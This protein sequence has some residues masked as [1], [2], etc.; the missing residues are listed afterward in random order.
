[1]EFIKHHIRLQLVGVIYGENEAQRISIENDPLVRKAIDSLPQAA[2]L[3]ANAK[4]YVAS[5][6]GAGR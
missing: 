3:L 4:R 2:Q 5:K 1:M 6:G